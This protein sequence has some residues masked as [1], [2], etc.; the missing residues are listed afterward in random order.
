MFVAALGKMTEK[1]ECFVIILC[2]NC[3]NTKNSQYFLHQNTLPA[4][5]HTMMME[6]GRD[7]SW[8]GQMALLFFLVHWNSE[9]HT[10]H[11]AG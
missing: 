3:Q 8:Q 4:F 9:I 1:G 11:E 10:L 2:E 5:L 6:G 7:Q